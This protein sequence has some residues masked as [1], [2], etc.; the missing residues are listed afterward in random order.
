MN[1]DKLRQFAKQYP[2]SLVEAL[3]DAGIFCYIIVPEDLLNYDDYQHEGK[4]NITIEEA[5]EVMRLRRHKLADCV[6]YNSMLES[7]TD[8]IL[9]F[10][11]DKEKR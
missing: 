3:F 1:E 6:D 8:Y 2:H 10:R 11:K 4:L 5:E 7:I 9:L